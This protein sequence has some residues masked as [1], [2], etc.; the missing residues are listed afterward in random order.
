[1]IRAGKSTA[2]IRQ[3]QP[4]LR[5]VV[6]RTLQ[7]LR[8]VSILTT[9][10]ALGMTTTTQD[11][12]LFP[13]VSFEAGVPFC[14]S[15][16]MAP[17]QLMS[18]M[19]QYYRGCVRI[20]V[21]LQTGRKRYAQL[22]SITVGAAYEQV[23]ACTLDDL[24]RAVMAVA[25]S[26]LEERGTAQ[27]YLVQTHWQGRPTGDPVRKSV[28]FALGE[29]DEFGDSSVEDLG[30]PHQ[31]DEALFSHLRHVHDHIL[32]QSNIIQQIGQTAIS[33]AGEVFR[34][35]SEAL[36]LQGRAQAELAVHAADREVETLK[37]KRIDRLMN[38][39]EQALPLVLAK[40]GGA[41]TGALSVASQQPAAL[42]PSASNPVAP[43]ELPSWL[44]SKP[45]TEPQSQQSKPAAE[46]TANPHDEEDSPL[47]CLIWELWDSFTPT[48]FDAV[49]GALPHATLTRFRRA[50]ASKT[51]SEAAE[52]L[53]CF[54]EK[55]GEKHQT[56]LQKILHPAQLAL[57]IRIQ[58]L[59]AHF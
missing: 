7:N 22:N 59:L 29:Q 23:P 28:L 41:P 8:V 15:I 31:V 4:V 37:E 30:D 40:L 33:S 46:S 58:G 24:T 3:R 34:A 14:S 25:Q 53:R 39:A 13:G 17:D 2:T 38:T 16:P 27:T 5:R 50:R 26:T 49:I 51:E 18:H 6:A 10:Y 44:G 11:P 55:L 19:R 20:V 36:E 43:S 1:M 9:L 42:P 52:H 54:V 35:R 32:K 47:R 56:E 57:L 45:K 48:Q 12:E 21:K